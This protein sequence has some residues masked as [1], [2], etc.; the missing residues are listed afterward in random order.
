MTDLNLIGEEYGKKIGKSDLR[1][2]IPY[3][4]KLRT[5]DYSQ[6]IEY[7]TI[8]CPDFVVPN[9]LL[10]KSI[11]N[12]YAEEFTKGMEIALDKMLFPHEPF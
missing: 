11:D 6:F 12:E 1:S 4:K 7:L 10:N 2:I 3:I 5:K 9:V 8:R